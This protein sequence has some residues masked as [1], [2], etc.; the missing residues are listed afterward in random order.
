MVALGA[1]AERDSVTGVMRTRIVEGTSP[2]RMEYDP[3]HPDANAD[4]Y[5]EF[6]YVDINTESVGLL[7]GRRLHEANTSVFQA[8]KSMRKKN[9]GHLR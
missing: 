5:V 4:G 8:A 6:S 9:L 2:G 3:D 7:I 1:V